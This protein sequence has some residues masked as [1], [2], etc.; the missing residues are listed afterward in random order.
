[1]AN[2][3]NQ[4]MSWA[5]S[6]ARQ[7]GVP[8]QL[9]LSQLNQESHFNPKA[10]SYADARGIAQI[11]PRWHPDINPNMKG[12]QL[13]G[14]NPQWD[15]AYAARLMAGHYKKYGSWDRAL[16]AY[17]S[18]RPDAYKDPG[19]AK[20]QT[21]NYVRNIMENQKLFKAGAKGGPVTRQA[22]GKGAVDAPPVETQN[23][24][25]AREAVR[26]YVMMNNQ[27]LIAGQP[28]AQNPA[29]FL[30]MRKMQQAQ[31]DGIDATQTLDDGVS[32]E[33]G[34]VSG[35][36]AE[37]MIAALKKAKAM[38]LRVGENPYFD[39]VERVHVQGSDHYQ[40]Y[41]GT[42]VGRAADI[43]GNDKALRAYFRWVEK[44]YGRG[45][46]DDMFYTPM[47]YSYDEG[48]RWGQTIKNHDDHL[49][50]SFR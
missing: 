13:P 26:Q 29:I 4:Y 36:N 5:R 35:S 21:Y 40:T 19:F 50:F 2:P 31:R 23:D 1:M 16:S 20:G 22:F 7:Y 42:K 39:P 25:D 3:R 14:I 8:E 37:N 27:A 24:F 10:R 45:V 44:T 6:Y 15:I 47:K 12:N 28:P 33:P 18:G 49:H 17:N 43:S 11:V 41:K 34:Q 32:V 9:F 48:R 30:M 38:G 46:L